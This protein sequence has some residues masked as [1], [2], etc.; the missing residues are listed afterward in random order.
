MGKLLSIKK[1][2]FDS[3]LEDQYRSYISY[4]DTRYIRVAFLLFAALY[5]LFSWADYLLVPQWFTF[6]FAI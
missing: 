6:F 4:R 2:R 5:A 1:L 3:E